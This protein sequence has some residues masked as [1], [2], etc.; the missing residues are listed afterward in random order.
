M[1]ERLLKVAEWRSY[2]DT[3][4]DGLE[5][6]IG[7][8]GLAADFVEQ[9]EAEIERL[10]AE[11]DRIGG[12]TM[13]SLNEANEYLR[14]QVKRLRE[15]LRAVADW[16]K[17]NPEQTHAPLSDSGVRDMPRLL[18]LRVSRVGDAD[19]GRLNAEKRAEAAESELQC[20][21][22]VAWEARHEIDAWRVYAENRGMGA[23]KSHMRLLEKLDAALA[24]QDAPK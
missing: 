18:W 9:L 16:S 12:K 8:F 20:L 21:R 15:A 1:S 22:E 11:F 6:P 14:A 17:N 2:Q 24:S 4:F 3:D 7:E 19:T 23:A 5:W 10:R 13:S